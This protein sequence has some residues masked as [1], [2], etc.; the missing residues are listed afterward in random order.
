MGNQVLLSNF[1]VVNIIEGLENNRLERGFKT[2]RL[3]IKH[4]RK[5]LEEK[6]N[7]KSYSKCGAKVIVRKAAKG[8]NAN[9]EFWV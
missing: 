1:K 6:S 8:R 9:N 2:N 3:H 4:V 7:S 5:I